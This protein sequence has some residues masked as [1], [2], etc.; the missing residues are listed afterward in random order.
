MSY[1]HEGFQVFPVAKRISYKIATITHGTLHTQQPTYLAAELIRN[2]PPHFHLDSAVFTFS[3]AN[4][5]Q[6]GCRRAYPGT[7]MHLRQYLYSVIRVKSCSQS[8]TRHTSTW[9]QWHH[10]YRRKCS[11][12]W[13]S[14][15]MSY[16]HSL[17][18]ASNI[19]Y[20]FHT[21][22]LH[23]LW[24][25]YRLVVSTTTS[26]TTMRMICII[27]N[28]FTLLYF[29]DG[30]FVNVHHPDDDEFQQAI[31]V[32]YH[33]AEIIR[34]TAMVLRANKRYWTICTKSFG[35][36]SWFSTS[37]TFHTFLTASLFRCCCDVQKWIYYLYLH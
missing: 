7:W 23:Q 28:Y 1:S 2:S 24:P 34:R 8:R 36:F 31:D 33:I 17:L 22:G 10:H 6:S 11:V 15:V 21:V 3:T 29:N 16:A 5:R 9:H 4:R 35:S 32:L 25:P 27:K 14:P 37:Y 30:V 12:G 18:H 26:T 20:R 13:T 19:C